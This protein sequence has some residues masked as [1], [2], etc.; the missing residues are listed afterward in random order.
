MKTVFLKAAPDRI[1]MNLDHNQGDCFTFSQ[2]STGE[3][4][5]G[6]GD[7]GLVSVG[8]NNMCAG[9]WICE[10]RSRRSVQFLTAFFRFRIPLVGPCVVRQGI[11][12]FKTLTRLEDVK[13]V[14][15]LHASPL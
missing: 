12:C 9:M 6:L 4:S 8:V 7:V 13:W 11:E 3:Q 14:K 10:D 2:T 1:L 15:L 5:H